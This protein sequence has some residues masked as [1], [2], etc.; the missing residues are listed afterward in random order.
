MQNC[1]AFL[2]SYYKTNLYVEFNLGSSPLCS[3]LQVCRQ[4]LEV[5]FLMYLFIGGL[6]CIGKTDKLKDICSQSMC[7]YFNIVL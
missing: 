2:M 3:D 1:T 4:L 5:F 6:W 7:E